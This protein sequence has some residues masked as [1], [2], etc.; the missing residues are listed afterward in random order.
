MTGDE[1]TSGGFNMSIGGDVHGDVAQTIDK[2]K[3]VNVEGDMHGDIDMGSD[4][5]STFEEALAQA[6]ADHEGDPSVTDA[7]VRIQTAV[8]AEPVPEDQTTPIQSTLRAS[9]GFLKRAAPK[10]AP[11]AFRAAKTA[12]KAHPLAG[13]LI[14]VIEGA[15]EDPTGAPLEAN[16]TPSE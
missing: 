13:L 5:P 8:E 2:S 14:G 16:E 4:Q 7:I 6:A 3:N 10:V 9:L 11:I 12:L 15:M 1:K